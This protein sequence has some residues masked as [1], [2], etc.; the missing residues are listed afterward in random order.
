M[1]DSELKQKDTEFQRK[2]EE[3]KSLTKK[4]AQVSSYLAELQDSRRGTHRCAQFVLNFQ[5]K[6]KSQD[7]E[8]IDTN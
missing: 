3:I 4:L 2:E 7:F 5:V 8:P 1:R 6:G